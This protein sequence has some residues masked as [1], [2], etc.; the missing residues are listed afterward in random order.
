[1]LT[2]G[3]AYMTGEVITSFKGYYRSAGKDAALIRSFVQ[4]DGEGDTANARLREIGGHASVLLRGMPPEKTGQLVRGPGAFHM[5]TSRTTPTAAATVAP[6]G[7]DRTPSKS[8]P[9]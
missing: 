1:M 6:V 7:R 4:F 8:S 5:E 3:G 9:C 2:T